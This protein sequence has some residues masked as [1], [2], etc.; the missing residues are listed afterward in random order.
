[1][2]DDWIKDSEI[3]YCTEK[4]VTLTQKLLRGI[5]VLHIYSI[6]ARSEY[7]NCWTEIDYCSESV[8]YTPLKEH[9]SATKKEVQIRLFNNKKGFHI[10]R[11]TE[12]NTY[13]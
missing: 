7:L 5:S 4:I 12:A 8:R 6:T 10:R 13:L 3:T 11:K 2:L 9:F 1:M